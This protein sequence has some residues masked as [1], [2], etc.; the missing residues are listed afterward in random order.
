MSDSHV[1]SSPD[2]VLPMTERVLT[3]PLTAQDAAYTVRILKEHDIQV[4]V[5]RTLS[6]LCAEIKRGAAVA[7][8][9]D[10]FITA[11]DHAPLTNVL[12]HQPAWSDLPLVISLQPHSHSSEALLKLQKLGNVT[13]V[14]RPVRIGPFVNTV[15]AKLRDRSRQY[16]VRDLLLQRAKSNQVIRKNERRL[17]MTLSA[18]GMATWEWTPDRVYWSD[19][20]YALLAAEKDVDPGFDQ[21]FRYVHPDDRADLQQAWDRAILHQTELRHEFRIQTGAGDIR[22]LAVVGEPV[23][24]K[25]DQVIHIAGLMWDISERK[26]TEETLR[27]NEKALVRQQQELVKLLHES[28]T[29]AAKLKV[30]FDQT[31]YF[32]AVLDLDG[33]L[34]DVN[35][36]ALS[37]CGYERAD[38]IGKPFWETAWWSGSQEVQSRIRNAVYRAAKGE[39]YHSELPY[40]L[41]DGTERVNDFIMTP[42]IDE[43]GKVIYILP[44]GLD[45][46]ERKRQEQALL[47]SKRRSDALIAASAQIVWTASANGKVT[48]DSPSWR[49]F[50]GQTLEEWLGDGWLQAVHPKDQQ[51]VIERWKQAVETIEPFNIEYR[52]RHH[53]GDW[54]WTAV[55]AVPQLG[56]N[57]SVTNWVGMNSDVTRQKRLQ[58]KIAENEK[59]LKMALKAGQMAAWEWTPKKSIWTDVLYELL[60]IP[61]DVV[62]TPEKFFEC[63]HPDDRD[64]LVQAWEGATAGRKSYDHEFRIIRPS[65]E[66]RW[67]AGVGH[68][69]RNKAGEVRRIYGLN[70]DI[71]SKHRA[72]ELLQE[73][74]RQAQQASVAKSQFLANMSHEIRTP[75][76]AV[77]GYAELLAA[78]EEDAERMGHIL[79]IKRNGKFLLEIIN[80][81]L[82]L[83]KI[84]AGKIDV[85]TERFELHRVIADVRSTMYVRAREKQLDF[86]VDFEDKIPAEIE[87]DPKRIRQ[88]LVNLI[89]NAIKFTQQGEVRL[90]VRYLKESG[91]MIQLDVIDTGVGIAE[92][93]QVHLFQPFSQADTSVSRKFGGTGLG[94]A[95]SQRLANLLGGEITCCSVPQQGSTFSCT[96]RAGEVT[97]APLIQP[98]LE[99]PDEAPAKDQSDRLQQ[100]RIL[101]VD[102]RRDVRFLTRR[103]LTDAG[104]DVETAEDGIEALEKVEAVTSANEAWDLILLDMQMP[105]LDGYQTAARLREMQFTSPIIALTADAMQG[106]MDLCLQSGCNAYLSKPIDA[107]QLIDMV[108][109][110]TRNQGS[111]DQTDVNQSPQ[112]LGNRVLVVEDSEDARELMMQLLASEGFDVAVANDGA[113][114]LHVAR[115]FIPDSVLIDI[116]LPDISGIELLQHMKQAHELQDSQFIAVTG[117]ANPGDVGDWQ[118][119]GFNNRCQ[120]PTDIDRLVQ[121]LRNGATTSKFSN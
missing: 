86:R 88:I 50:T 12:Q 92:D 99:T 24:T 67:L 58:S 14:S 3:L 120:K 42:V 77:L 114:A 38:V 35:E 101:V 90:A 39:S 27:S 18:A 108:A 93:Q 43:T 5:C 32:A 78:K 117:D 26:Q 10:E 113:T 63:V 74:E 79:T 11:H 97:G 20:L 110:Y 116:H 34:T 102:D 56:L 104:A 68:V 95:I 60:G 98:I 19:A 17:A 33:T 112:E 65:G 49:R 25:D 66:V 64:E 9:A 13:L 83:S 61:T 89:G 44:T 111:K 52:L 15:R 7:V 96:V 6:E 91:P 45:V 72:V 80:D 121:L 82:D 105:R 41:A 73:R 75:M 8:I 100:R 70:W 53:T 30:L 81:I 40:W 59:R 51:R 36:L 94:L 87:S 115:D 103:I 37:Q 16:A 4:A 85:S 119:M 29:T 106:D 69:E 47:N 71:T 2:S 46:T 109:H 76:T 55:R 48:E 54:R 23:K 28:N 62:A 22:W 1:D 107:K 57:G 31:S 21:F 118:K 84:E